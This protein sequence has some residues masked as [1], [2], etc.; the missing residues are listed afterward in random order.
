LHQIG[1]FRK[2]PQV[3]FFDTSVTGSNGSDI[4]IRHKNAISPPDEVN[5]INNS[6]KR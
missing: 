4:V 5:L 2:T 6:K 3:S 1:V